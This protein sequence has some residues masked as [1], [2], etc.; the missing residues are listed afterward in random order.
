MSL[1]NISRFGVLVCAAV[2]AGAYYLEYQYM[3]ATCP[4]CIL[5]RIMFFALG[6]TFIIGSVVKL[7]GWSRYVYTGLI[8]LLAATGLGIAARQL[9]LQYFAPP[10]KISCAASLQHLLNIHPVFDALKISLM[11]SSECATIDFTI[12]GLSI[13]AWSFAMFAA[14]VLGFSYVIWL[15]KNRRI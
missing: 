2:L 11:G 14:I 9:W 5:Q 6:L 7:S 12:F 4:L 1:Q 8:V 13:A 3:L 10:Q 15:Q